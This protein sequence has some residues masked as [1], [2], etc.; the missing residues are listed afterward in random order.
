MNGNSKIGYHDACVRAFAINGASY[1]ELADAIGCSETGMLL[2]CRREG[3]VIAHRSPGSSVISQEARAAEPRTARMATMYRQGIT[4]QSIGDKFGVTRERVRQLLRRAGVETDEGGKTKCASMKRAAQKQSVAAKIEAKWGVP[5]GVWKECRAARIVH[6][7]ERQ[8]Q[9]SR[10]RGIP[11]HLTFAQWLAIWQTSGKLRLC[12]RGKGRYC[13]SR[14]EDSGA[15]E[16][17]NVH[18]QLCT[19]NSR[20]AVAKWIGK[21]KANRGVF[22]LYPGRDKAWL[23][24]VGRV[25]LGFF[26]TEAEAVAARDAYIKESGAR[27]FA[28][29]GYGRGWSFRASNKVRPYMVQVIGTKATFHATPEEA[30]AEY[31]RRAAEVLAKRSPALPAAEPAQA[32]G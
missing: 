10:A 1:G 9:N 21:T 5:Y 15:Y 16:L 30:R 2:Y 14:L 13:L 3:I 31:L 26:E 8:V 28:T 17:G 11:F 22:L 23:A 32:G 20:D 19:D 7:Y 6:K 4:L 24:R 29:L 18:V 27:T 12:G 25:R